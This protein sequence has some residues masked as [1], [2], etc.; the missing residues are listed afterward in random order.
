M[1][2]FFL[3]VLVIVSSMTT[4]SSPY[5]VR[6]EVGS[7]IVIRA[8]DL[9]LNEIAEYRENITLGSTYEE[10][11]SNAMSIYEDPKLEF[12][13]DTPFNILNEEN[14]VFENLLDNSISSL[15]LQQFLS[16]VNEVTKLADFSLNKI[17]Q[18]P[19]SVENLVFD[20]LSDTKFVWL[21]QNKIWRDVDGGAN[22]L[23]QFK[24]NINYSIQIFDVTSDLVTN[25]A[26]NWSSFPARFIADK[27][28]TMDYH[29]ELNWKGSSIR[30]RFHYQIFYYLQYPSDDQ[31]TASPI[32]KIFVIQLDIDASSFNY[33]L[34]DFGQSVDSHKLSTVVFSSDGTKIF[35]G[36]SIEGRTVVAGESASN[37]FS[38]DQEGILIDLKLNISKLF[39]LFAENADSQIGIRYL[40][41]SENSLIFLKNEKELISYNFSEETS[42]ILVSDIDSKL[43]TETSSIFRNSLVNNRA[44]I[45][46][47]DDHFLL[48][49]AGIIIDER[50]EGEGGVVSISL[51][52]IFVALAS[53]LSI[54][55]KFK[56]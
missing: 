54:K 8:F 11:R 22:S 31:S 4:E 2:S 14:I 1:I 9:A 16:G 40:T 10:L 32:S 19:R 53:I 34:F 20:G 15:N 24:M 44:T 25:L 39:T 55:Q 35:L 48:M 56:K 28:D 36:P 49:N 42:R 17:S 45:Y 7:E 37:R 6:T 38:E 13:S 50:L 3:V 46:F 29:F 41:L 33:Y 23:D 26:I 21:D 30:D 52:I 5:L 51:S 27:A 43:G 47:I 18:S 12:L